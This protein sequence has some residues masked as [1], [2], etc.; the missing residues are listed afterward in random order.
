MENKELKK[1]ISVELEDDAL[2]TVSGGQ[3]TDSVSK[4]DTL[5]ERLPAMLNPFYG[6]PPNSP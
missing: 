4:D 3:I 6:Y 5:E 1:P 2:D